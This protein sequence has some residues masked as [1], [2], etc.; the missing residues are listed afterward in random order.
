VLALEQQLQEAALLLEHERRQWALE[1]AERVEQQ[2]ILQEVSSLSAG[3]EDMEERIVGAVLILSQGGSMEHAL[4]LPPPPPD[5]AHTPRGGGGG[6][7]G[8]GE[9]RDGGGNAA[10]ASRGRGRSHALLDYY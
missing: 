1:L 8:G 2:R 4:P 7:G 5:G 10:D 9:P 6:V 3:M